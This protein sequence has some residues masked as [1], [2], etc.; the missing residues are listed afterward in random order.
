MAKISESA[1]KAVIVNKRKWLTT[2]EPKG[3]GGGNNDTVCIVVTP[4]PPGQEQAP[5]P[6]YFYKRNV[7]IPYRSPR[8]AANRKDGQWRCGNR[9]EEKANATL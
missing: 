8:G 6:A 4:T 9:I 3:I 2:L 1:I 7:V 5:N